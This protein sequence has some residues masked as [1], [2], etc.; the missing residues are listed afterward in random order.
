MSSLPPGV[1]R[2]LL[3]AVADVSTP[4]M[5]VDR[6]SGQLIYV[7]GAAQRLLGCR[8]EGLAAVR[9]VDLLADSRADDL[10]RLLAE[11]EQSDP[12]GGC[13]WRVTLPL[14][15]GGRELTTTWLVTLLAEDGIVVLV[16]QALETLPP[17]SVLSRDPLTKLPDRLALECWMRQM[18][19][20]RG[21]R[22]E[23]SF[24]LLFLDLDDFKRVNDEY[25]H[26]VGDDLLIALAHRLEAAIRPGDLAARYGGDEFVVVLD[27]VSD[28]ENAGRI[29]ARL[30]DALRKPIVAG[31]REF[32]IS[33]SI[34]IALGRAGHEDI[35]GLLHAADVA[36]YQAKSLGAGRHVVFDNQR[37]PL[38]PPQGPI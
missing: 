26:L 2:A 37:R 18:L 5:L 20:P 31:G 10:D 15:R 13:N 3:A 35:G 24:A 22:C 11:P 19:Q 4:V 12:S 23:P 30:G 25:G 14:C 21:D 1:A 27:H 8:V 9:L 32:S 16:G 6:V 29:A 36:M 34:G 7:N 28:T 33:A 17:A 38:V